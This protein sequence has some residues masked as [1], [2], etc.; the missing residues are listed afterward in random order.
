MTRT[1]LRSVFTKGPREAPQ[2]LRTAHLWSVFAERRPLTVSSRSAFVE[3]ATC[4]YFESVFPEHFWEAISRS[5]HRRASPQSVVAECLR[6]IQ[7]CVIGA[8][9]QS[10]FLAFF[11][12]V[13]S[14]NV[15]AERFHETH[16]RSAFAPLRSAF[17]ERLRE[18][19]LF[20]ERLPRA[21][22]WDAFL[23]RLRIAPSRKVFAKRLCGPSQ[24]A[25][26]R[27]ASRSAFAERL[28]GAF[29]W[30]AFPERL[31]GALAPR[32]ALSER[33]PRASPERLP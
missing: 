17:T 6:A 27:S 21:P 28:Q 4:L 23:E 7:K 20:A 5:A 13:P 31:H 9:S 19:L 22:S 29:S 3:R 1:F 33:L 30:S 8:P 2:R 25:A 15:F 26:S 10:A 14:Q 32:S 12:R 24:S 16:L 11:R 18:A